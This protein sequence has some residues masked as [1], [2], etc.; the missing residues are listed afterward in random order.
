MGLYG[1]GLMGGLPSAIY[2]QPNDQEVHIR[3]Q[4][5][6]RSRFPNNGKTCTSLC[7]STQLGLFTV[8]RILLLPTVLEANTLL[9]PLT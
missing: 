7:V 2:V 1:S 9:K 6:L 3:D 5:F 8:K 4:A